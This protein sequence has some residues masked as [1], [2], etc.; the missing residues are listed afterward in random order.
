[1]ALH[2]PVIRKCLAASAKQERR[3]RIVQQIATIDDHEGFIVALST[4][5]YGPRDEL[6]SCSRFPLDQHGD[7][8]GRCLLG[9]LK[10]GLHSR[11]IRNYVGKGKEVLATIVQPLHSIRQRFHPEGVSQRDLK[12]F[13]SC[14]LDDEVRRAC[15]HGGRDIVDAAVCGLHNHGNSQVLLAHSGEYSQAI[16]IGHHQIEH[17]RVDCRSL[18]AHEQAYRL[19]AAFDRNR[20]IA[21]ALDHA[22]KMPPLCR[23][24]IHD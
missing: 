13:E 7:H 21:Q 18:R 8:R 11:R 15:A 16:K 19:I 20:L 22:V 23:I 17:D 12:P 6:L 3:D 4:P 24:V 10:H 9:R 14:R 5:V 2:F 1:M